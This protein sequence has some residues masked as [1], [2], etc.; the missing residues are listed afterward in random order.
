MDISGISLVIIGERGFFKG[1]QRVG[2]SK[3]GRENI[4]KGVSI[5]SIVSARASH[6]ST[7]KPGTSRLC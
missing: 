4:I 5:I 3:L 1:D 2:G 6:W 7:I